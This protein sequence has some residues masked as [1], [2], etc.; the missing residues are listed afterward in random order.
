MT[1]S[2]GSLPREFF[3]FPRQN[4][5]FAIPPYL[6][7]DEAAQL[8]RPP[9]QVRTLKER[10][11]DC[12]E[13]ELAKLDEI[14][15]KVKDQPWYN[16]EIHS[17][18]TLLRYLAARSFKVEKSM[19]MLEKTAKW[20]SE[21][22][23]DRWICPEC[24][25]FPEKHMMQF[26]GWDLQ[27]RPVIYAS[28]RWGSDR[29]DPQRSLVHTVSAFNHAVR[30][31]P[32]GVEQWVSMTDFETYSHFKDGNP[33]MGSTVITAL[34]DHFPERLA[35][36]ILV[37]PP[38][39]FSVLWKLFS[40]FIDART[41]EKVR[42]M[43]TKGKPNIRDEFPKLFPAHVCEYLVAAFERNKKGQL[44]GE[45]TPSSPLVE[46]AEESASPAQADDVGFEACEGAE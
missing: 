38:T 7:T 9:A 34:Q 33:R 15:A 8:I 23:A 14:R 46:D 2:S 20:Y 10:L 5:G 44:P 17:D 6:A 30:L 45:D 26:V 4:P 29:T 35:M 18:W 11:S 39:M 25:D 19:T 3:L 37:N 40:P 12:S 43:Y 24:M 36:M 42:F 13:D 41:K 16:A 21:T 32:E 22:G 31:M 28:L 1:A 27:H